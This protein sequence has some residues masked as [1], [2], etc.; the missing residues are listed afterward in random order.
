MCVWGGG[1]TKPPKQVLG[2]KLFYFMRKSSWGISGLPG[3]FCI[4]L[5]PKTMGGS[6]IIP[7]RYGTRNFLAR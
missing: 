7:P 4:E 1:I 5:A 3:V 6:K 2:V